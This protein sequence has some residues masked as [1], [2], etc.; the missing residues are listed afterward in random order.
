MAITPEYVSENQEWSQRLTALVERLTDEDLRRPMEAG[1]TVSAVLAHLAF[2]DIRIVTLLEKYRKERNVVPSEVDGDVINEVARHLCLEIPP[3]TAAA[4]ALAWAK[5]ADEAIAVLHPA[6]AA[7]I[8]QKAPN[9][10][11]D[12]A[13]HRIAHIADIEK[14]LKG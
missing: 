6:L 11:L 10:R 1:W 2:W 3:R 12:R 9:V 7:E 8:Q 5:K 13:H 14:A 4:M